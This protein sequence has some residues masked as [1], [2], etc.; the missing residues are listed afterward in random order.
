M[1]QITEQQANE[2][3]NSM[4]WKLIKQ[5]YTPSELEQNTIKYLQDEVNKISTNVP[6]SGNEANQKNL[7]SGE[8]TE[9]LY[10]EI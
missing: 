2:I 8:M 3:L 5:D 6:V 1:I 10:S 9:K 7:Q 4:R